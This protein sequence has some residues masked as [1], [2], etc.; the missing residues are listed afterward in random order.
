MHFSA[1]WE[2][3]Y[4][5]HFDGS[6]V[7]APTVHSGLDISL[8]YTLGRSLSHGY[9]ACGYLPVCIAFPTFAAIL[10]G[11]DVTITADILL[12]RFRNGLTPV[13]QSVIALAISNKGQLTRDLTSKLVDIF[14]RFDCL[15][16][17]TATNILKYCERTGS[18]MYIQRPYAA[19]NEIRKGIPQEYFP[20][21][22]AKGVRGLYG[23]YIALTATPSKVLEKLDEP[24]ASSVAEWRVFKYLQQFIGHM[25]VEEV[26]KFL[27]FVICILQP[28]KVTFNS[29]SGL[30][31]RPISH[32]C[33]STL[34]LSTSYVTYMDFSTE[35]SNVLSQVAFC[36]KMDSM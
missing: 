35:F 21:W 24:I 7:L 5:R 16:M 31:R 27:R 32:T 17:P 6:S 10:L 12:D 28:I 9:L 30:A 29:L 33:S 18:Y 8:L 11:A 13:D 1:F 15:Q 14:S 20:F 3:A 4:L 34:E 19:I 23:L 2:E 26:Q 36:W 25:K 22:S